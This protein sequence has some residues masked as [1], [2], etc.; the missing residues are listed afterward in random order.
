M[1]SGR[2]FHIT[3]LLHKAPE[4]LFFYTVTIL[5]RKPDRHTLSAAQQFVGRQLTL[6]GLAVIC[7][8]FCPTVA[9]S[10]EG[11]WPYTHYMAS[12]LAI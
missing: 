2:R 11:E 7:H 9:A 4:L 3:G 6:F 8:A 1:I 10:N 12:R 5:I